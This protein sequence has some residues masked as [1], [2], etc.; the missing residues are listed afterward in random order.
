M[1]ANTIKL[2]VLTKEYLKVAVRAVESGVVTDPTT[3]TVQF[4][5]P[6]EGVTPSVW[7][8]GSWETAVTSTGNIY[9]GRILVGVGT[10][11]AS[12]GQYDVWIR[13]TGGTEIPT[14]R[15]GLLVLE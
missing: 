12:I 9:S 10:S 5:F 13:I 15:V 4:S 8:S 2:S 14:R 1:S 6:L 7:T 11:V 3:N